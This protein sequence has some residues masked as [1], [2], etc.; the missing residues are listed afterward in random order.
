MMIHLLMAVVDYEGRDPVRAFTTP[1]AAD[2]YLSMVQAHHRKRPSVLDDDGDDWE[3]RTT[4]WAAQH[5][6][7][8]HAYAHRFELESIPLNDD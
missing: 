7:P 1:E 8:G 2:A 4:Q 3:A 5:P 6:A